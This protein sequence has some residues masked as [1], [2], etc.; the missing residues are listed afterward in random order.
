MVELARERLGEDADVRVADLGAP[1]P[2]PDD[3]FDLDTA[4]DGLASGEMPVGAV[5]LSGDQ[6]LGRAFTQEKARG[7]RIVHADL[8]AMEQADGV[9]GF[10]RPRE[11]LV[12]AVSLEPCLMCLGAAITLGVQRVYYALESPNDGGVDLLAKWDPP[13]EQPFFSRPTEIRAGFHRHRSQQLF[14][15]YADGEGPWGMR[16][17]AAALAE[18]GAV[19]CC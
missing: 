8:L 6:I 15:R 17:W 12:L 10:S 13:I 16:A 5:V 3:K 11:P 14:R 9:L 2:Y 19:D 1:L 7:R 4:E 18:Q